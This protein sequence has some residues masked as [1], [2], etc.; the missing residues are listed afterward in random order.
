MDIEIHERMQIPIIYHNIPELLSNNI[1]TLVNNTNSIATESA[2]IDALVT[3]KLY[4]RKTFPNSD[5][6]YEAIGDM[7]AI[8]S[9]VGLVIQL[10]FTKNNSA[11]HK[12]PIGVHQQL[13][14]QP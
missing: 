13:L 2:T 11:A 14:V 5:P 9:T 3:P 1:K 12:D 4:P 7:E 6:I 10:F 8:N